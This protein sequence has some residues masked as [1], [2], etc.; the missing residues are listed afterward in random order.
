MGAARIVLRELVAQ[1]GCALLCFE[2]DPA[3]CHR[4][5]LAEVL[6]GR[7]SRF[8]VKHLGFEHEGDLFGKTPA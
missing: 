4:S 3:K 1:G 5:I 8:T 2:R 6:A 7:G